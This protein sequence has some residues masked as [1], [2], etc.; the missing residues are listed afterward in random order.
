MWNPLSRRE[1]LKFGAY[2]SVG[3]VPIMGHQYGVE[4]S[5]A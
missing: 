1:V 5:E 2:T 4:L 3:G